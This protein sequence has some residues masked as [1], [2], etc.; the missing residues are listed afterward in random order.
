MSDSGPDADEVLRLHELLCTA[1]DPTAPARMAELLLPAL[2]RRFSGTRLA[3]PHT[4][5]S[6]IGLSIA[7]YLADPDRWKPDR[8]PLLAYLYRDVGGD[9]INERDSQARLRRHEEPN[10]AAVELAGVDRNLNGCASY[11]T[12]L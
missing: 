1:E 8:A 12:S 10:S 3:D 5:E 7:R 11:C 6:L 2:R 4:V 9:V